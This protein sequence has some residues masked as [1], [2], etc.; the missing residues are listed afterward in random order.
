[1]LRTGLA[2][3]RPLEHPPRHQ[4]QIR[5]IPADQ[6][7]LKGE[8][9]LSHGPGEAADGHGLRP[10]SLAWTNIRL[11]AANTVATAA[12]DVFGSALARL[13]RGERE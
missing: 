3:H 13:A 9:A 7:E 10:I 8:L 1:M 5:E 6:V 12:A 4:L 11:Q 2:L